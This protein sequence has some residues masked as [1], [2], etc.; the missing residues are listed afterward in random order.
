[1]LIFGWPVVSVSCDT[2]TRFGGDEFVVILS[3]L[4]AKDDAFLIVERIIDA[5]S[6][7]FTILQ[8]S[9]LTTTSIGVSFSPDDGTDPLQL[10][11]NADSA[12]YVAKADGKSDDRVYAE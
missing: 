4:N 1:M 5:F 3:E 6:R 2:A 7:P 8:S 12:M 11:N 10:L 9:V